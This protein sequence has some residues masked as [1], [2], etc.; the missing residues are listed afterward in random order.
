MPTIDCVTCGQPFHVRPSR[1]GIRKR[2]S[3][4]CADTRVRITC[5][6]C[7]KVVLRARWHREHGWL[8]SFCSRACSRSPHTA[9]FVGTQARYPIL[10]ERLDTMTADLAYWLGLMVTDGNVQDRGAVSFVSLDECSTRFVRDFLAPE[11]AIREEITKGGTI[12]YRW[13]VWSKPLVERLAGLGIAP[14]KSLDGCLPPVPDTVVWDFLRGVL[15][16]D[17]HVDQAGRATFASGSKA[18]ADGL[19]ALFERHGLTVR[20][21]Q[22]RRAYQVYLS[23][24]ASRQFAALI[25]RDGA[26]HL[27]RKRSR[28]H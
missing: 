24:P 27:A 13:S 21:R 25:Y 14:R 20:C 23:V 19:V 5:E 7:G 3:V 26:P 15:D 8:R 1:V 2:C 16:G 4:A 11:S 28:F 22:G 18:L 12:A 9:E 6:R 10:W 17:G